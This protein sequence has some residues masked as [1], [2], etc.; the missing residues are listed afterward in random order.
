MSAPISP[1]G[2]KQ[3]QRQ[4]IRRHAGQRPR[5]VQ[6]RDRPGE[7]VARPV[8]PRILEDRPEDPPRL[9]IGEGIADDHLPAERLRPRADH[10]DRLRMAVP[11]HEERP[12]LRL[13]RPLAERHRLRRRRRLVEQ[14]RVRHVQ[15]GQVAD[16][17]LEVQQRLQPPLADLRL[18]RRI[19]RVPGRV[20]EDVPLDHRRRHRPVVPLPD[21]A[22][23]HPVL[24]RRQPQ[25]MQRR[26]LAQRRPELQRLASPGCPPAPSRRSAPR[27]SPPPPPA[28]SPP[29]PTATA[30]YAAGWRNRRGGTRIPGRPWAFRATAWDRPHYVRIPPRRSKATRLTPAAPRDHAQAAS[31]QPADDQDVEPPAK[32]ASIGQ[33]G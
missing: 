22:G 15:P 12:R 29:S 20:L 7:V 30:R 4:R 8:G 9:E 26:L 2:F 23:Q 19:G 25:P 17:R 14:R 6:R 24:P 32:T 5:R 21:Q 3:R 13:R 11:V 27:G 10:V 18:I 16:H 33:S 28:A 31:D 1:G